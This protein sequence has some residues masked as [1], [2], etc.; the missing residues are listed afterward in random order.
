MQP[1]PHDV[2]RQGH[3]HPG[4][5]T[6]KRLNMCH[7]LG[8]DLGGSGTDRRNLATCSRQANTAVVGDGRIGDHMFSYESQVKSAIDGGQVVR[9]SVTPRYHGSRTVPV[10]FEMV[11]S[12]ILPDGS[13]GLSVGQVVPNSIYSPR[14][15]VWKNLGMVTDSRNGA[16]VP[17]GSM[18]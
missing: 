18:P 10:S 6:L 11:A 2:N 4:A 15:G 3:P 14:Q 13:P 12:G 5:A 8:K 16:P 9:Y 7:L 1:Q 17:T